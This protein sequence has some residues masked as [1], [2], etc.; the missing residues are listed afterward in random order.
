LRER[1]QQ[2]MSIAQKHKGTMKIPPTGRAR[3][4]RL[5]ASVFEEPSL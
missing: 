1:R 4:S 5:V 3:A 2:G